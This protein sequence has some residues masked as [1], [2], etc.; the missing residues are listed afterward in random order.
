MIDF[1]FLL[2]CPNVLPFIMKVM[3]NLYSRSLQIDFPDFWYINVDYLI[4]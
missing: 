2:V 3:E 4:Y 1:G